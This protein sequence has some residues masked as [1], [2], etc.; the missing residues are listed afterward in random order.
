MTVHA[1]KND[2]FLFFSYQMQPNRTRAVEVAVRNEVAEAIATLC[3]CSFPLSFIPVGTL[4]CRNSP[5]Y[6][7]YRSVL[8]G[9]D[10]YTANDLLGFVQSW[11]QMSPTVTIDIFVVNVD[12]NC[13][14]SISDTECSSPTIFS[15]SNY[16]DAYNTTM[17]CI[18]TCLHVLDSSRC[19]K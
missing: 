5:F 3:N 18:D 8:V 7:T 15:P 17:Q 6:V 11:V 2:G 16:T 10:C 19:T 9:T 14:V 4:S 13:P 1:I 12:A